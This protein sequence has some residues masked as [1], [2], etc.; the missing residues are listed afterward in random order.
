MDVK[1]KIKPVVLWKVPLVEIIND[2]IYIDDL[3]VW[4]NG[5]FTGVTRE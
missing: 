3:L 1:D 2:C 4:R 5:V